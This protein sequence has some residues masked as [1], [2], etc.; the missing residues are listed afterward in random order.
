LLRY[1]VVVDTSLIG[2]RAARG[3]DR[4]AELRGYP[5]MIDSDNGTELTSNATPGM[6]A[7]AWRRTALY[8]AG[9]ADAEWLRREL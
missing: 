8:R 7:A 3:L 5:R 2:L 1:G 6:A 4:I 9:Q